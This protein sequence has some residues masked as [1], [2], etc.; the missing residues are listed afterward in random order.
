MLK[1]K[2]IYLY[3]RQ[4]QSLKPWEKNIKLFLMKSVLFVLA[5]VSLGSQLV[6]VA[7]S[8]KAAWTSLERN[9]LKILL[10]NEK[11]IKWTEAAVII[12]TNQTQIKSR[13]CNVNASFVLRSATYCGLGP[14]PGHQVDMDQ[15][16]NPTDFFPG[17]ARSCSSVGTPVPPQAADDQQNAVWHLQRQPVTRTVH[18]GTWRC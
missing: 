9:V 14:G 1:T 13:N 11:W 17:A 10:V 8:H 6:Y 12:S 7:T 18:G 3:L 15:R 16:P 2:A 4:L 5:L